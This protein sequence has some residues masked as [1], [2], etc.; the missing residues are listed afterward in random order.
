MIFVKFSHKGF[1][2][3][4]HNFLFP[5]VCLLACNH[6]AQAYAWKRSE[7]ATELMNRSLTTVETLH[8]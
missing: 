4:S 2:L 1:F 5:N 7:T 3:F 8:P 6:N